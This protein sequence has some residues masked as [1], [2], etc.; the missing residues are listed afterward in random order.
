MIHDSIAFRFKIRIHR[1]RSKLSQL[2]ETNYLV[3]NEE[4]QIHPTY[5]NEFSEELHKDSNQYQGQ[6]TGQYGRYSISPLRASFKG[7]LFQYQPLLITFRNRLSLKRL[8][9]RERVFDQRGIETLKF[10]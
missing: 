6:S 7:M 1:T 5:L 10:V 3:L 9:L 2:I 4:R 8:Q